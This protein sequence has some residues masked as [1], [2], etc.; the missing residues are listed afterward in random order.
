[1][2]GSPAGFT[3]EGFVWKGKVY[4]IEHHA[5]NIAASGPGTYSALGSTPAS[6][7]IRVLVAL[8]CTIQGTNAL[9]IRDGNPGTMVAAFSGVVSTAGGPSQI[10]LP[11]VDTDGHCQSSS[12]VNLFLVSVGPSGALVGFAKTAVVPLNG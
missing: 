11:K 4:P 2:N 1:M 12:G 5:L 3:G 9:D 8:Y 10:G 7:S 6:G